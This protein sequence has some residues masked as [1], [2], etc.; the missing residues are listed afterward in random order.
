MGW[1]SIINSNQRSHRHWKAPTPPTALAPFDP[2]WQELASYYIASVFHSEFTARGLSRTLSAP[3]PPS[4]ATMPS[5]L[6]KSFNVQLYH[7][8]L[9]VGPFSRNGTGLRADLCCRRQLVKFSLLGATYC[10]QIQSKI[11]AAPRRTL[12]TTTCAAASTSILI[13]P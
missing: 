2:L 5:L 8:V 6:S 3:A 11:S 7:F 1:S 12:C 4:I 10:G 13:R 9:N